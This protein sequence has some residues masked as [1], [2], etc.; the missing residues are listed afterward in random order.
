MRW[1]MD[2]SHENLGNNASLFPAINQENYISDELHLFLRIV[3]ILM[4]CFFNDLIKKKE[5]E[6]KIKLEIEQEMKNI[7]VHFEFFKSRSTGEKWNWTF[8]MGSDKKKVLEHFS[9]SQFISG[10][11]GQDIEKLWREFFQLYKIIQKLLLSDQEI[12]TF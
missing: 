3:D 10:I 12:D 4:K 8:L 7:N 9:V 1:D 11:R 5:F 6:K 2:Q